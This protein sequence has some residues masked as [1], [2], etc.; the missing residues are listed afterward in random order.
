MVADNAL[1]PQ[2]YAHAFREAEICNIITASKKHFFA[3]TMD[4]KREGFQN[5][6][7]VAFSILQDSSIF[8]DLSQI[9]LRAILCD[10]PSCGFCPSLLDAEPFLGHSKI[11]RFQIEF[12]SLLSLSMPHSK[13]SASLL[14]A[15]LTVVAF[16][17]IPSCAS[18]IC[19]YI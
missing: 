5:A 6:F 3:H 2:N 4:D 1:V 11:A 15:L 16:L 18:R 14:A 17:L 12:K 7:I 8:A 9:S 10:T 19:I 13:H